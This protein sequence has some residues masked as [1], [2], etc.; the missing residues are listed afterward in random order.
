MTRKFALLVALILATAGVAR[1][2]GF[3]VIETR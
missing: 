2:E 1:A 3:D